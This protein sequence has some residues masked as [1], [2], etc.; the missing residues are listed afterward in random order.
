MMTNEQEQHLAD[1]KVEFERQVDA[2][3]RKGQA[4]HGGDLWKKPGVLEM[5]MDEC[6]DHFVY[7]YVLREQRDNPELV[8]HNEAKG[9]IYP[10]QMVI[11]RRG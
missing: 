11:D 1:I 8:E 3:Y 7:L 2:K 5:A 10:S 9:Y 6:V 4:E